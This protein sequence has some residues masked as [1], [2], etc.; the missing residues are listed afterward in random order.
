MKFDYDGLFFGHQTLEDWLAKR[1]TNHPVK[2]ATAPLYLCQTIKIPYIP[3]V[4]LCL[5]G[6]IEIDS[7]KYFVEYTRQVLPVIVYSTG[8]PSHGPYIVWLLH[9]FHEKKVKLN[10]LCSNLFFKLDFFLI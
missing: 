6:S 8:P 2:L 10:Y 9:F 7:I 5:L 3:L 1:S 4:N